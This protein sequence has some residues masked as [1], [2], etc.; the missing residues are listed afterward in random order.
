MMVLTLMLLD[1]F[2]QLCKLGK[3]RQDVEDGGRTRGK[4]WVLLELAKVVLLRDRRGSNHV[5]D[6]AEQHRSEPQ[7]E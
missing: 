4:N 5:H 6:G 7:I 3:S 2:E 1:G